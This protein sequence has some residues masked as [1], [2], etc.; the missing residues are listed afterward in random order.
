MIFAFVLGVVFGFISAVPVAGPVSAVV[1]SRGMRGKYGQ[2]RWI[3]Y[4]A[5]IV[6]GAYTFLAFW[7]FKNFLADLSFIFVASNIVAALILACLGL[8]FFGAKKLRNPVTAEEAEVQGEKAFFVGAGMS[9][10]NPTLIATWTA[11]VT[12]LYSTNLFEFTDL[13]G[14]LFSTGVAFGIAFWFALMLRLM[15]KNLNR[16]N[17]RVLDVGLKCVGVSL[18]FLSLM[19]IFRILR[20]P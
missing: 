14:M 6:E 15:E 8:Y 7:G 4:G 20:S 16:L 18:G 12:T 19:M 9:L 11:A 2:G 17:P 10:V 1:F 13:N 3:A 5:A